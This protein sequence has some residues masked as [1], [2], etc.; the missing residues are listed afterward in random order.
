VPEAGLVPFDAADVLGLIGDGLIL[1]DEGDPAGLRERDRHLRRGHRLHDRAAQRQRDCQRR[2]LA[3]R[4][5]YKRRREVDVLR[6][7]LLGREVRDQQVLIQRPRDLIDDLHGTPFR[8]PEDGW[9]M[10]GTHARY[11]AWYLEP[12]FRP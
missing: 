12:G 4:M 3:D 7:A 2:I 11:P 8:W 6:R 10:A 1:V 9:K 5:P